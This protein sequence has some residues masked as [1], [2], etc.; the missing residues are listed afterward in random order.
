MGAY[1]RG[2][3]RALW[4]FDS[5]VHVA[6]YR[7][8]TKCKDV[9]NVSNTKSMVPSNSWNRHQIVQQLI[10]YCHTDMSAWHALLGPPT[11]HSRSLGSRLQV[12]GVKDELVAVATE[13]TQEAVLEAMLEKVQER[14]RVV[15]FSLNPYKDAKDTFVLVGIDDVVQVLEESLVAMATITASRYAAGIR[16]APP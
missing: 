12:V 6:A 15:E 13:A 5:A 2:V 11:A 4:A 7:F 10:A 3:G 14:W 1:N 8:L 16:Q 9:V